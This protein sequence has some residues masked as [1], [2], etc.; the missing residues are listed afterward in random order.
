[1]VNRWLL[2]WRARV[3]AYCS[4]PRVQ[5]G[6]GLIVQ[7]PRHHQALIEPCTVCCPVVAYNTYGY[8]WCFNRCIA[9]LRCQALACPGTFGQLVYPSFTSSP[10][11]V[12]IATASGRLQQVSVGVSLGR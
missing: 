10:A 1:M 4:K 7:T 9:A 11:P 5:G 3:A 8:I 6:C 2:D 12:L